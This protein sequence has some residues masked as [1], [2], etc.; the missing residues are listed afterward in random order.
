[1]RPILTFGERRSSSF[2]DVPSSFEMGFKVALP[3]FRS[4]VVRAETP[5]DRVKVLSDV[6]AK[7]A[8]TRRVQ[9]IPRGAVR[10]PGQF[11]RRRRGRRVRQG[12]TR[13]HEEGDGIPLI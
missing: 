2:K 13:G 1:M 11:R 5:P 6:L 12:A 9:E 3:Q 4:I 8:A 7:V 10:G